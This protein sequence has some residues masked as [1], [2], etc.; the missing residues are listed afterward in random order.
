MNEITGDFSLE[1]FINSLQLDLYRLLQEEAKSEYLEKY[2]ALDMLNAVQEINR[3]LAAVK[4]ENHFL[5]DFLERNDPKMLLGLKARRITPTLQKRPTTTSSSPGSTFVSNTTPRR[6]IGSRPSQTISMYNTSQ[7]NYAAASKRGGLTGAFGGQVEYRLNYK[8]K[9]DMAEKATTEVEK[10][11]ND[12]ESKAMHAIKLLNANIE[13]LQFRYS[14]TDETIKNFQLHFLRDERDLIFLETAGERQIER[15]FRKFVNIWLKNARALLST[16]RLRITA[17]HENCQQLRSDLI[18][19]SD[20]SGLLS[21]VDFEQLMIKRNELLNSLDEKNAHMAGL[22][23]V[24]GKASLAMSEE[25]Q[26]MMN[27]EEESKAISVKTVDVIKNVSQLEKEAK[28]V[29]EENKKE[30]EILQTLKDQLDRYQAPS[31]N[32][33]VEKKDDL[34]MLEK[35]E[36]MLQRKIYILNMK[37]NN[38]YNRCT[39]MRGS[40]GI[41]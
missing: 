4:L 11:V 6:S 14:E 27:I 26:I 32:Q 16:M 34:H 23:G 12:V 5:T 25:K 41:L 2:D 8:A 3:E 10:R 24:T 33:Y 40:S 15:K 17:L 30:L 1:P 36:K 39:K 37:L 29:E 19:K 21:A 18:T 35:E 7:S 13:E 31:V 38:V 9:C 28:T 20:L 22:K